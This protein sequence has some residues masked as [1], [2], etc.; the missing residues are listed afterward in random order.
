MAFDVQLTAMFSPFFTAEGAAV[1]ET[2][3][4]GGGGFFVWPWVVFDGC[5]PK[6]LKRLPSDP[7]SELPSIIWPME[8]KGLLDCDCV[9]IYIF[10]PVLGSIVSI[11][12]DLFVLYCT[13]Y[14]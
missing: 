6:P 10:S 5:V 12:R 14:V 2:D 8:P 7:P 4:G 13:S 11:T 3:A 1:I 9:T